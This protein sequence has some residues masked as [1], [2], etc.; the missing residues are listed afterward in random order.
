MRRWLLPAALAL[1]ASVAW[2]DEFALVCYNYGCAAED[3]AVFTDARLS[4][5]RDL[6]MSAGDAEHEREY[7][8]LVIGKLYAWAGQQ[9]PIVADRG[10]NWDDDGQPGSMDCID[11]STTTT[12]F[13][14]LLA[15]RGWL[16]YHRVLAPDWRRYRLI[17]QH[18]SAV[19]LD[20]A[21]ERRYAVDSW[22]VDNGEPAV[23]LPIEEWL[24]GGGPDVN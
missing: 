20:A 7:L 18:F 3:L 2:A 4:W 6:M 11:H 22:F 15:G 23:V 14:N 8:A 10:G 21:T 19:I 24:D 9:T 12:R 13:L 1:A 5:V 16:R 17:G